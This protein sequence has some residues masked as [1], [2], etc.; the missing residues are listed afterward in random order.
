MENSGNKK[1]LTK[2]Y[3]D[4]AFLF[5]LT[6]IK[7]TRHKTLYKPGSSAAKNLS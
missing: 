2:K 3:F 1:S 6:T 4:K 5:F 7:A